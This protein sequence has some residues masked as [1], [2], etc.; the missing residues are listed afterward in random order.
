LG[1]LIKAAYR[2]LSFKWHPDK[3][4]AETKQEASDRFAAINEA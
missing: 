1:S 2:K 4:P 3:H